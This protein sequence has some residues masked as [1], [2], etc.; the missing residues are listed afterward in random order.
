MPQTKNSEGTTEIS[1]RQSG[2]NPDGIIHLS[3]R[4]DGK[5]AGIPS[6]FQDG[7]YF[8]TANPVRFVGLISGIALRR[9]NPRKRQYNSARHEIFLGAKLKL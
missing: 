2:W 5:M 3:G 1:Q 8:E 6:S 7:F 4:D 9:F